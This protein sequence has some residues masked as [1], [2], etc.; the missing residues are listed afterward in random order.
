MFTDYP[1]SS[2]IVRPWNTPPTPIHHLSLSELSRN[3]VK[4]LTGILPP[5]GLPGKREI[6][7]HGRP[8]RVRAKARAEAR[9]EQPTIPKPAPTPGT[10][11]PQ[12]RVQR[13]RGRGPPR[14]HVRMGAPRLFYVC[15][16]VCCTAM[17]DRFFLG[18][19]LGRGLFP[20]A[21]CGVDLRES[22]RLTRTRGQQMRRNQLGTIKWGNQ[23]FL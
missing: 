23:K 11:L 13:R 8:I 19:F 6:C 9:S 2:P 21:R 1:T 3:R 7:P 18:V 20:D 4:T 15:A 5:H 14:D 22:S 10:V 16:M 17:Q 12:G